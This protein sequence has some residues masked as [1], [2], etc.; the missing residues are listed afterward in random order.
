MSRILL[1]T[2]AG[3]ALLTSTATALEVCVANRFNQI[4]SLTVTPTCTARSTRHSRIE[5]RYYLDGVLCNGNL[6]VPV[7]G[8]CFGAPQHNEVRIFLHAAPMDPELACTPVI[9][10]M[11]GRSIGT[12]T[13]HFQNAPYNA[14]ERQGT[15]RWRQVPCQ[16]AQ[17]LEAQT[18]TERRA[19]PAELT[20]GRQ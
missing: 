12:A 19:A 18:H 9:W 20:P 7:V 3:I 5:G 11:Q 4:L 2:L 1:C 8:S 10:D 16:G 15:D 17:A 13:G 14:L 6:S